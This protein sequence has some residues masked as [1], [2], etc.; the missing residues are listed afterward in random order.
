MNLHTIAKNL[1]D[2]SRQLRLMND[3]LTRILPNDEK[4][5]EANSMAEEAIDGNN[6]DA[7]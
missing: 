5:S 6:T 4:A 1:Y 2:I 3:K 7:E